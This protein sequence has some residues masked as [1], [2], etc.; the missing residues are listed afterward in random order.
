MRTA[1]R[2][3]VLLATLWLVPLCAWAEAQ[4]VAVPQQPIVSVALETSAGTIVLDLEAGRAPITS[5]NFLR[6]VDEKRFDGMAFYRAMKTRPASGLIQGGTSNDPQRTL[7]PI[8]HEPTSRTGLSH[9]VGAIS[10]A[11]NA[12][13]TATGDF[14]IMLEAMPGLD[15]HPDQP[16]DNQGFAVFGHVSAGMDVALRILDAPTSPTLG[17]GVMKGQMLDPKIRIISA[18]RIK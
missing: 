15:A 1:T 7:P 17:E 10:M 6:Y 9:V 2:R 16:G 14:F 18:R 11:R 4:P 13:G 8:A 12:P 3:I 5:S